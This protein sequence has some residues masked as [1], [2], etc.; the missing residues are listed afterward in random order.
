M[1]SK[2]IV[3]DLDETLGHYAE[4]GIFL[5]AIMFHFKSENIN[6]Q[7]DQTFFNE[8][9]N[10]YPELM[11][12]DILKILTY[13]KQKKKIKKF[14]KLMI[15]T[16]NQGPRQ[17][18]RSLITYFETMIDCKLFDQIISAFKI[19]NKK[20]ELCRTTHFKTRSDLIKCAKLSEQ[21]QI[22]FIDDSYFPDMCHSNVYYINIKPYINV[23]PFDEMCKR[24]SQHSCFNKFLDSEK[25]NNTIL[26][27]IHDATGD[28]YL[29]HITPMTDDEYNIHVILSKQILNH[30]DVFFSKKKYNMS[31]VAN[32]HTHT[33][34]HRRGLN[35]SNKKTHK[36]KIKFDK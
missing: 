22:C 12:P 7:F 5:D 23:V 30:L 18:S 28:K 25:F 9:L 24:F 4:F 34:S 14:D 13:L 27:Y 32:N 19:N 20:I 29:N 33:Y 1:L 15:Y 16:N 8:C 10:L 21:T 36:L 2:V 6:V 11:R 26:K 35:K 17:W 31:Y 3:L